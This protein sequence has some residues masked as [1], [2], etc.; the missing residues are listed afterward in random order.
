MADENGGDNQ[1]LVSVLLDEAQSYGLKIAFLIEPYA[2]LTVGVEC[3]GPRI[4]PRLHESAFSPFGCW[5]FVRATHEPLIIQSQSIS[6]CA[7]LKYLPAICNSPFLKYS[8][9]QLAP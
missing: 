1:D 5:I 9:H 8:G 2:N 3:N 4:I 7:K 6:A